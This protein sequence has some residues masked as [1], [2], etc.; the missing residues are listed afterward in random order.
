MK[1]FVLVIQPFLLPDVH[2]EIDHLLQ[3]HDP[4]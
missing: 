3:F 2:K 4:G 1:A